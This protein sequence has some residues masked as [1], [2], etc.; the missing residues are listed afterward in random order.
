MAELPLVLAGPVLRRVDSGR[1]CVWVALSKPGD[2]TVTVF[3]G[4]VEST[5][6]GT[7]AAPSI[8]TQTRPTRK[9]GVNLHAVVVDVD[10]VGMP[11]LSRHCYDVVVNAGGETKGLKSLG[12]L[13][14]A[15]SGTPRAVALGYADDF[16]PSFVTPAAD[17]EDLRIAH[18]S[19][20]KSNGPGPDALAW[21]DDRIQEGLSD[22]DLAPQQLFLTGDQIYADDLGGVLLPMLSE[23]R[24]GPGRHREAARR[25]LEPRRD[26]RALPGPAPAERRA[27][28]GPAHD[29]RRC[30]PPADVRRVR[31]DV[32]RRVQPRRLAATARPAEASSRRCPAT[33][34]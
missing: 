2:V 28:A 27:R 31:G 21:L 4:R 33:Q 15:T 3:T 20:R 19:C 17:I 7:A 32:L 6:N 5:G 29:D 34:R 18:S 10:V 8:G 26:V 11:P 9:F 23:D 13:R 14:D 30:Q 12:M 16:L 24:E 25:R 1:V 22:L